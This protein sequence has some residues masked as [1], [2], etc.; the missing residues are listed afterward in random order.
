MI[1]NRQT[2]KHNFLS[3]LWHAVFLALA[4]NFMD[5]NTIIP[6]MMVDAS[7]SAL[8]LGF[9]TAIML[10][11]GKFSQLFFAPFINK[12]PSKKGYLLSGINTRI[13][14]LAGM[15]L[16]FYFSSRFNGGFVILSIFILISLFSLAGAFANINYVDIL[17]KSILQEKRKSFFSIKQIISSVAVLLSAFFARSVLSKYGYPINY[18]TLFFIAAV[19]LGIASLGS[20]ID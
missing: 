20:P 9:L 3:F 8:Q 14:A 11:F 7:A 18:A 12:Q 5:M 1:L 15:A 17:G 4:G 13:F 10:G 2:S 16:L 6:A 19:L